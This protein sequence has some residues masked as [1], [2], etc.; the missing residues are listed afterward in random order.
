MADSLSCKREEHADQQDAFNKQ[1]HCKLRGCPDC[2]FHKKKMDKCRDE[3]SDDSDEALMRPS[4]VNVALCDASALLE[5]RWELAMRDVDSDDEDGEEPEFVDGIDFNVYLTRRFHD[6]PNRTQLDLREVEDIDT[7]SSVPVLF[8]QEKTVV[9]RSRRLAE[10]R[11]GAKPVSRPLVRG[12]SSGESDMEDNDDEAEDV[13]LRNQS[14]SQ[15]ERQCVRVLA[16]FGD[17]E[18]CEAQKRDICL[19][20]LQELKA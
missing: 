12:E 13:A 17:P 16:G 8:T 7:D 11:Q 18:W 14:F 1:P 19:R 2:E 15:A 10:K 9:R 4:S 6:L 20:R 5:P 3:D